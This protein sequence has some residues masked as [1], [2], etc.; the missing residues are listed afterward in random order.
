LLASHWSE[1]DGLT[2]RIFAD[3]RTVDGRPWSGMMVPQERPLQAKPYTTTPQEPFRFTVPEGRG[4]LNLVVEI[5]DGDERLGA[6]YCVFDIEGGPAWADEREWAASFP[7]H[8]FSAYE[9]GDEFALLPPPDGPAKV[10]GYG[11]GAVEYTLRLPADLA[12][13]AVEGGR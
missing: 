11:A 1:R 7:V 5:R 13:E 6:N 12:A 2:L 10:F 8:A 4:I 3:G 9:F